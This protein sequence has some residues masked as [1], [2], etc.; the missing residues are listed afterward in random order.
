M[1]Q[2]ITDLS[3]AASEVFIVLGKGCMKKEYLLCLLSLVK[4]KG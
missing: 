1:N 3:A 4:R 2:S